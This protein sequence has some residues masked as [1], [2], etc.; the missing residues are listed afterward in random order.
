MKNKIIL[1]L[2]IVIIIIASGFAFYYDSVIRVDNIKE[3]CREEATLT[4]QKQ[5]SSKL[6]NYQTEDKRLDESLYED[7]LKKH[8][9][10]QKVNKT[11]TTA[12]SNTT[13]NYALNETAKLGN[14]EMTLK[15]IQSVDNASKL[16]ICNKEGNPTRYQGKKCTYYDYVGF[17][18][19][20]KNTSEQQQGWARLSGKVIYKDSKDDYPFN[21]SFVQ[22][23]GE[24]YDWDSRDYTL[25][26]N[27]S[28]D[29]WI[30][31]TV[32]PKRPKPVFSFSPISAHTGL[33]NVEY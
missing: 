12:Q 7:C 22:Y 30:V 8:D 28:V 21:S 29:G 6:S 31:L 18:F 24:S 19:L 20:V 15:E 1:T 11:T 33:W 3:S 14:L 32:D 25:D 17:R 9:L 23:F 13:N 26:P 2:V 5:S 27:E 4:H 16:A 10:G